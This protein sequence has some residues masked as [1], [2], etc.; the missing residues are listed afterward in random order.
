MSR[1]GD[2]NTLRISEVFPEDE[3]DYKCIV[4]NQG[5]QVEVTAPL[6]VLGK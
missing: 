2:T 5:G 4:S 6:K 3:G 1:D